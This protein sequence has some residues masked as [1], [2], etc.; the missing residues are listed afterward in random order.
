M[1]GIKARLKDAEKVKEFLA[2]NN[3]IEKAYRNKN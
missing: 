2:E 3:L 1:I